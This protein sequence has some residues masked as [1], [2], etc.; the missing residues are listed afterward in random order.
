MI[1][2]ENFLN[3]EVL[4][5][6][7]DIKK[8]YSNQNTKRLGWTNLTWDPYL[9]G[10]SALTFVIPISELNEHIAP[11][12]A[13]ADPAFKDSTIDTQFCVWGKGSSIPFHND[14]HVQ[15]AA[16]VYLN[17]NWQVEDGGLFLWKDRN[18]NELLVVSP[19][20]N[21]CV[22]N[23]LHEAHHVSVVSYT[24]TQPRIT[25]Q[26]WAHNKDNYNDVPFGNKLFNYG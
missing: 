4:D 12:F 25:L 21:M 2:I 14:Q 5:I 16:T 11:L 19:E 13:K 18:T 26:I 7:T 20:Y 22:I 23:D 17:D 24:S 1:I 10:N 3:S 6:V 8:T 15:F 9:H